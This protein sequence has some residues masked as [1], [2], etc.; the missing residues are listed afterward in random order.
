[1]ANQNF[2]LVDFLLLKMVSIKGS[3]ITDKYFLVCAFKKL[4][5]FC[6]HFTTNKK[7]KSDNKLK[8]GSKKI[9][10][11]FKRILDACILWYSFFTCEQISIE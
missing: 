5:A 6:S 1:M 10:K 7:E 8:E 3:A 11:D 4:I 2:S 9:V